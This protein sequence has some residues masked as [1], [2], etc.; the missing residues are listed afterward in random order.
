MSASQVLEQA[1]ELLVNEGRARGSYA[2]TSEGKPTY[3][4][5]DDAQQ[6]CTVGAILRTAHDLGAMCSYNRAFNLLLLASGTLVNLTEWNDL[7]TDEEVLATFDRAI[8]KE[9]GLV[10]GYA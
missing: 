5:D 7:A 2:L 3:T 1:R 9:R 6:F 4:L 8:N 10:A